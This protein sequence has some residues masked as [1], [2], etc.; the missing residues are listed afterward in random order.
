MFR[1]LTASTLVVTFSAMAASSEPVRL[2]CVPSDQSENWRIRI[3]F[4]TSAWTFLFNE[5]EWELIGAD[6]VSIV[7]RTVTDTNWPVSF[8]IDRETGR[9]WR[10]SIGRFCGNEDCSVN[11]PGGFVDEGTCTTPF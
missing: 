2:V 4:D 7:A 8:L 10:A 5:E 6:E 9:W 3:T 1:N 11:F